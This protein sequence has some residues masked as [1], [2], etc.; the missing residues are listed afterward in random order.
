[1]QEDGTDGADES[2]GEKS[3][4]SKEIPSSY[5]FTCEE[6]LINFKLELKTRD[7]S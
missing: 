2:S 6:I 5:E 1:M 3:M 7:E 4:A